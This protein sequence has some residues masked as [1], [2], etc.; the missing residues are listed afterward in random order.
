VGHGPALLS[1]EA[2]GRCRFSQ[3]T[4]AVSHGNGRDAPIAD[5]PAL[6]PERGAL[7]HKERSAYIGGEAANRGHSFGISAFRSPTK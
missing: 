1:T 5:L 6:S 3:A 4:F 7:T 2:S